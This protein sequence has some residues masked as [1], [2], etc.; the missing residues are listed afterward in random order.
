MNDGGVEKNQR[1]AWDDRSARSALARY[2]RT[3]RFLARRYRPR[4]AV[5]AVLDVDDLMAVGRMAVLE[6]LERYEA[7]GIEESTFV[8]TRVQQRMIDAIRQVDT[9]TREENRV[10]R[11]HAKGDDS[12]DERRVR[13][14]AARRTISLDQPMGEM[15]PMVERLESDF[16]DAE[17]LSDRVRRHAELRAALGTLPDRQREAVS[18]CLELGL[19]LREIGERMG[20]SESRVCQLQKTAVRRLSS[21]LSAAA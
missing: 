21:C 3:V 12:V 17:A 8:R 13:A 16:P 7:Y 11:A 1:S 15:G 6:A 20:I 19:R 10:L 2:E 4:G 5:A 18:L 14:I 9:R